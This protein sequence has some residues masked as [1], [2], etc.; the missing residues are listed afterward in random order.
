MIER[1][2][3]VRN[4][5][6]LHARAA[7]RLVR[8]ASRFQSDIKLSRCNERQ[9]VDGKS[10]LGILLLAARQGTRLKIMTQGADEEEAAEAVTTLFEQRFGEEQ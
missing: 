7:A 5:R 10:I 2:V 9:E 8:L 1:V 4:Q 6:G 3:E